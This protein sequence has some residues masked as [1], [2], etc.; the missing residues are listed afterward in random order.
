[1]PPKKSDKGFDP[2]PGQGSPRKIF[3]GRAIRIMKSPNE[4][5]LLLL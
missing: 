3:F 4:V 2:Q 1:M 5:A